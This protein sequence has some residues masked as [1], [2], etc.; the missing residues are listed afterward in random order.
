VRLRRAL[1]A[2]PRILICDPYTIK[3]LQSIPTSQPGWLTAPESVGA[4][5][6]NG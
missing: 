2:T 4:G 3:L 6:A 1:A 5:L